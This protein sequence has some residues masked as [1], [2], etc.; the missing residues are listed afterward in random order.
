MVLFLSGLMPEQPEIIIKNPWINAI[1]KKKKP[2][3]CVRDLLVFPF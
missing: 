1:G 2:L 3:L